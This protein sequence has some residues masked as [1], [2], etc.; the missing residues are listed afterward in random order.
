M[1]N[2]FR[3]TL[4]FSLSFLK[5]HN[6]MQLEPICFVV[7]YLPHVLFL[8]QPRMDISKKSEHIILFECPGRQLLG[9]PTLMGTL[10]LLSASWFRVFTL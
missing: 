3:R 1:E 6:F 8:C 9:E 4:L 2:T 10:A 7:V 5:H